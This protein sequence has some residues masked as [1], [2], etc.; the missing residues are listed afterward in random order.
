[1]SLTI[2]SRVLADARTQGPTLHP[3]VGAYELRFG[4]VIFASAATYGEQ[5]RAII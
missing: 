3:V 1:M 2:A 5:C 4:L